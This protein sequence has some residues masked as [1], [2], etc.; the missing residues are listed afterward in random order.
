MA[1]AAERAAQALAGQARHGFR[2]GASKR[3]LV[4]ES[5]GTAGALRNIEGGPELLRMLKLLPERMAKTAMRQ[6]HMAAGA[7]VRKAVKRLV[8][9]RTGSL[10]K[11]IGVRVYR[12]V[13]SIDY[14]V[15]IGPRR[16]EKFKT[17]IGRRQVSPSRYAH[18]VE[19]G[20]SRMPARSFLRKGLQASK[21][22]ALQALSRKLG[23]AIERQA[24]KLAKKGRAVPG[25]RV[26]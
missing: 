1:D 7:E 6:A 17:G 10:K 20:T 14:T 5:L 8:P 12:N 15:I 21:A 13:P 25:I 24:K 9:R 3:L 19:L 16:G 26:A 23:V 18:L 4:S 2:T 11:S 22:R